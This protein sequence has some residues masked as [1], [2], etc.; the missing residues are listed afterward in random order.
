MKLKE[1]FTLIELM[2]V[3]SII[4]LLASLA[5]PNFAAYYEAEKV[6]SV[7]RRM[8]A[9][10]NYARQYAICRRCVTVVRFDEAERMMQLLMPK[11]HAAA[12]AVQSGE[13]D[14]AKEAVSE[15]VVGANKHELPSEL[16][17]LLND[18]LVEFSPD[19]FVPLRDSR[20][21][22]VKIPEGIDVEMV[23]TDTGSQIDSIVF[24]QDGTATGAAVTVKGWRGFQ[25][26]IFVDAITAKVSVGGSGPSKRMD[27]SR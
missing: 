18:R 17:L 6:R 27:A 2:V 12:D 13:L 10:F 23:N 15:V 22:S 9:C 21:S 5:F 11:E 26:M 1:A 19:R 16:V 14:A 24:R 4:A 7:S 25:V 20:L 8:I 3:L